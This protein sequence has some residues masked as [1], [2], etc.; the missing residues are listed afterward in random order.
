M[1]YNIDI[2]NLVLITISLFLAIIFPFELFLIVYAILGPLHYLTEINWIRNKNYFVKSKTWIYTVI[3]FAFIVSLPAIMRLNIFKNSDSSI[4]N[5]LN[6]D[7]ANYTNGL[8]FGSFMFAYALL[9][10]KEKHWQITVLVISIVLTIFLKDLDVYNVW[11]GIF[12]PTIIHV[13]FFTLLF[14]W[15]GTVKDNSK[16][17]TINIVYLA[18]IPLIIFLV[19]LEVN[20]YR[21]SSTVESLIIESRFHLLNINVSKFLGLSDGTSFFFNE[22]IDIKIQIFIAFAYTYLYLNWFS[23]TSII[24]WHK[25]LSKTK[26]F[27]IIGIWIISM[28]IYAVDYKIG[29]TLLLMLSLMHVFFEF[30]L[31]LISIK[32]IFNY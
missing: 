14:M 29:L 17:G 4:V 20:L 10:I 15:Y 6:T 18:L 9:F 30:P 28:I 22:I 23:K 27:L 31:Y 25:N 7:L 8:I 1:R 11:I 24:G 13:Y 3:L 2:L 12:L 19:S 16:W 5:F 21:F 32:G 26:T